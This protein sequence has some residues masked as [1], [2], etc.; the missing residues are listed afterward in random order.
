MKEIYKTLKEDRIFLIVIV[1]IFSLFLFPL[2]NTSFYESHDGHAHVA[3]FAA[4]YGAIRDG[5]LI[6][7]WAGSLNYHYGSPLFIFYYPLSGYLSSLLH[8]LGASFENSFKLLIALSFIAAP[9]SFYFWVKTFLKK[10]VAFVGAFFY[11]LAPFHMLDMYVR[12]D[13][14]EMI[15]F[16]LI[17]LVFW[18]LEN[19]AQKEQLK[20]A[21]FGSIFLGFLILSHNGLSLMFFPVFIAYSFLR[22]KNVQTLLKCLATIVFGLLLSSFF[23]I[24]ALYEGKYTNAKLFI[25]N[26]YE[27]HFPTVSQ[28]IYSPWGF[29]PDVGRQGGLSPQIG[30][31][32]L[33][34]VLLSIFIV[35]KSTKEKRM[36]IGWLCIFGLGLFITLSH[37]SFFWERLPLI[38]MF[39]FPWRFTALSSFAA[40]VLAC[41]VFAH[42][43]NKKILYSLLIVLVF[44]TAPF[45]GVKKYVS[46]SDSYYKSYPGTTYYHG[47]ASPIWTEGDAGHFPKT[48]VEVIGGRGMIR[49]VQTK[50]QLHTYAIEAK[51]KVA[52]LDNTVYF[53]GWKV[54]VDDKSVPVQFQDPNHR[55][56]ITFDIPK[57]THKVKVFFRE[58]G[59]RLI[60][61]VLSL[62]CVLILLLLA[63]SRRFKKLGKLSALLYNKKSGKNER[64]IVYGRKNKKISQ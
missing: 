12:G 49:D 46:H 30:I 8:F 38:K 11:G 20:F 1:L 21:A 14:A 4:Y 54:F 47:E 63:L 15:A 62:A 43:K 52:I 23:W 42:I 45:V 27:S 53:P 2:F 25:G 41:Y 33:L 55:G 59:V 40:T 17:P 18:S 51:D 61:D 29:G 19:I 9:L 24:P 64:S 35:L 10:E 7:R 44:A 6:P 22:S 31:L 13:V 60:A 37:S 58:T 16:A 34:L 48:R 50:S 56:F 26:L 28:L 57:G 36:M 39:E 32:Y 5:Q 3:R